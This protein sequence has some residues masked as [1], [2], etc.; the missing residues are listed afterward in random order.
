MKLRYL[1]TMWLGAVTAHADVSLL[2]SKDSDVYA[3]F[4]GPSYSIYD[5]N[6]GASGAGA[7]HSHHALI[8]FDVSGVSIPVSRVKRAVL[9]LYSLE[10]SSSNGGGLRAG[11]LGVYRQVSGWQVGGLKWS[12]LQAG[13]LVAEKRIEVTNQWVEIEVT[14]LVRAWL[15]GS[16]ENHGFLLKPQSETVEPWMN[17]MFA[18]MELAAAGYAPRLFI[19]EGEELPPVLSVVMDGEDEVVV[20]W[21]GE[22]T[23]GWILQKSDGDFAEWQTVSGVTLGSGRGEYRGVRATSGREFF[24]LYRP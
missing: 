17:A 9:R 12:H 23:S 13:E 15:D 18:S 21:S 7:P 20:S 14:S 22:S 3:F 24:R 6:I 1:L 5:L 10:P 16:A 11:V 4:D 2:P 19:E 8:Q